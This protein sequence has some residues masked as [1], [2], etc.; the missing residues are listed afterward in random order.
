MLII[1]SV[2]FQ[3]S[4]EIIP[5]QL[6]SFVHKSCDF[7]FFVYS[8]SY[9]CIYDIINDLTTI[10]VQYPRFFRCLES[11]HALY[12]YLQHFQISIQGMTTENINIQLPEFPIPSSLRPLIAIKIRYR[13][14][15]DW[16]GFLQI[17]PAHHTSDG[18]CHLRSESKI[19]YFSCPIRYKGE[20]ASSDI[21]TG[22]CSPYSSIFYQWS[23]IFF[24]SEFFTNCSPCIKNIFTHSELLWKSI[25]RPLGWDI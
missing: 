5:L 1:Q 3:H 23:Q 7:S 16:L 2:I 9:F 11:K 14:K 19:A 20:F 24:I 12:D 22:F 25:T 4:D 17:Y 8:Q 15:S 13:E 6:L 18:R 21:F 10:E